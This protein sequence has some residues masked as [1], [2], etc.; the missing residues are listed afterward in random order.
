MKQ[1]IYWLKNRAVLQAILTPEDGKKRRRVL[2]T[3]QKLE[4][5]RLT[6]DTASRIKD[7]RYIPKAREASKVRDLRE[8]FINSKLKEAAEKLGL[9]VGDKST[10]LTLGYAIH[11]WNKEVFAGSKEAEGKKAPEG[12]TIILS[13]LRCLNRILGSVKLDDLTVQK[14][15]QA[16]HPWHPSQG[17][18]PWTYN[19]LLRNLSRVL[20]WCASRKRNWIDL[21]PII[22]T[23]RK[24]DSLFVEAQSRHDYLTPEEYKLLLTECE[25]SKNEHL[26][27]A[28][29]LAVHTGTRKGELMNALWT[30]F[31]QENDR[32]IFT[33]TKNGESKS[34][35][36]EETASQIMQDRIKVRAIYSNRI[37]PR[38]SKWG[39]ASEKK[40]GIEYDLK[41]AP[42]FLQ[43]LK[44]ALIRAGLRCPVGCTKDHSDQSWHREHYPHRKINW[45]TLR[46]TCASLI[47]NN[48]GTLQ[49]I[50][51][52][53]GQSSPQSAQIY[54]HLVD[55]YT[56]K[57]SSILE[58][59]LKAS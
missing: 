25:R 45:H 7:G 30:D 59:A 8:E 1:E 20:T 3:F 46:H 2:A 16:L 26:F 6:E 9:E 38:L 23:G 41:A 15:T 31:D 18:S 27:D 14:I 33:W 55:D 4:D 49:D 54:K 47:A 24:E 10:G 12:E 58:K 37:F 40:T 51:A 22:S 43:G 29:V 32:L 13:E 36:L 19:G 34:V 42:D 56:K 50:Q 39:R 35:A 57:T 11:Q 53:L 44:K 17:K 21:N 48:G 52:H 28:V 5:L